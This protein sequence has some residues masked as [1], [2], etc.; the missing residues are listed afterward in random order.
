MKYSIYSTPYLLV[1]LLLIVQACKK[2]DP[3]AINEEEVINR[4]TLK[5]TPT[6]GTATTHTWND[7]DGSL[8]LSLAT[9]TTY[10]VAVSFYDASDPNAIEDITVEV[11]EEAD[12]HLVFFDLAASAPI[13]ISAAANDI[14]DS[15]NT[16]LGL[17]TTWATSD[18]GTANA[19]L[20]LIHEPTNKAGASRSAVGGET[21]VEINLTIT[22]N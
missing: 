9:N 14:K 5:V 21:D 7:G 13:Q 12:E 10:Q 3:V 6:G 17:F 2:D 16:P 19:K 18:T 22:I 8:N 1:T 20:Y 4:V 11:R 15:S